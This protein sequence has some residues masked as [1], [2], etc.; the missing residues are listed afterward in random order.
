MGIAATVF[1][2]LFNA[3]VFGGVLNGV[4]R[5]LGDLRFGQIQITNNKGDI[6]NPDYQIVTTLAQNLVIVAVA[7][8]L[9]TVSE[10]NFTRVDGIASKFRV[11]TVGVDLALEA[12]ASKIEDTIVE[13]NFALSQNAVVL[14]ATVANDLGVQPGD[15]IIIKMFNTNGK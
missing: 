7:P 2:I 10:I 11:E 8:R 13:G 14:G 4:V 5:D 12:R 9:T 1:L 15:S 3:I 6:T